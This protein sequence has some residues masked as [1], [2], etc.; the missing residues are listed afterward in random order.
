MATPAA[1]GSSQARERLESQI[2]AAAT[3][4]YHSNSNVGSKQHQQATLILTAIPDL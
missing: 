3:G 1:Y 4:L 2:R